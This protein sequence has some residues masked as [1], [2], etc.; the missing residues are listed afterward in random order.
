M[1]S[2]DPTL[3]NRDFSPFADCRPPAMRKK[4]REQSGKV[5]T[6]LY[7]GFIVIPRQ[8]GLNYS[9]YCLKTVRLVYKTSLHMKNIK[10]S[11]PIR[12]F[13]GLASCKTLVSNA[14]HSFSKNIGFRQTD[15]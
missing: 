8:G 5:T 2:Y 3:F 9:H 12:T 7:A 6:V 10:F 11:I 14:K 15:Y 1:I 4:E 13:C